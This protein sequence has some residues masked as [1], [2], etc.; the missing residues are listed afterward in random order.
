M[1]NSSINDDEAVG[2][3]DAED[4]VSESSE[5]DKD[6]LTG[7]F[8]LPLPKFTKAQRVFAKDSDY[9]MIYE[10]VVRR[11]IFGMPRQRQLN[12]SLVGSDGGVDTFNQQTEP[13]VPTWHYFLHYTGWNVKWD[14]WA[15]ER[16]LYEVTE[17]TRRF[18]KLISD[19]VKAIKERFKGRQ[20]G[21]LAMELEK[22]MVMLEREKRMEEM[23]ED[24]AKRG[25]VIK[26]DEEEE[27]GSRNKPKSQ[28]KWTKNHI[29]AELKLNDRQLRSRRI[30]DHADLLV[31][32][33]ALKKIMVE[34]W[35]IITQCGMIHCLPSKVSVKDALNE[36]LSSKLQQLKER[37]KGEAES[38]NN[39]FETREKMDPKQEWR[40]MV[41]G[42]LRF[43][44]EGIPDRFLYPQELMQYD[45]LPKNERRH[46]ELFGCEF[47][48]RMF[49]RLPSLM[50][51]QLSE[52]KMRPILSK[53]ND[54]V[55]YLLK[56]QGA[57]FLQS[58]QK[59]PVEE[60]EALRN[61]RRRTRPSETLSKK[62]HASDPL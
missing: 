46:C 56:H 54:L 38:L 44:D 51:E 14:R 10:A 34:E 48:L 39:D 24:M 27:Y 22:M 1:S 9:G 3:K 6:S 16:Q 52:S 11:S 47:L 21:N 60:H 7:E 40:N 19:Q 29:A 57:L 43:F 23:R 26:K 35:E 4:S 20:T 32:P 5:T 49:V 28:T 12:V 18:A 25:V 36:Y 53:V 2:V 59:P 33:L 37:D 15:E 17:G 45:N 31:L 41:D 62:V 13:E 42:I 8:E 30:Q 55:R 58:Y 50:A 61:K